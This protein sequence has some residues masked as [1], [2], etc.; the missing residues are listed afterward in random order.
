[1]QITF[2]CNFEQGLGFDSELIYGLGDKTGCISE[3][4]NDHGYSQG[5]NDHEYSHGEGDGTG[6]CLESAYGESPGHADGYGCGDSDG[7]G[8]SAGYAGGGSGF[9]YGPS[10]SPG[11][12]KDWISFELSRGQE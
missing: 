11:N 1:M 7:I 10:H 3:R 8:H 12:G 4:L 5:L 6:Y 9:G 2:T